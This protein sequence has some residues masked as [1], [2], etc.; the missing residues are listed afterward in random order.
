MEDR[1]TYI[2]ICRNNFLKDECPLIRQKGFLCVECPHVAYIVREKK[3]D[4]SDDEL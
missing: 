1:K 3:E 2:V 4:N